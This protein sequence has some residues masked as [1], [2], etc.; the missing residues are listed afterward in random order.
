M[1]L[2]LSHHWLLISPIIHDWHSLFWN[3]VYLYSPNIPRQQ[4]LKCLCL[5]PPQRFYTCTAL[6][7]QSRIYNLSERSSISNKSK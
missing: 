1:E 7:L 3:I 6:L 5:G 2:L 4:E